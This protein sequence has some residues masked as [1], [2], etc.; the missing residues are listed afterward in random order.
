MQVVHTF[1]RIIR[2]WRVGPLLL[3]KNWPK[4]KQ[5][6]KRGRGCGKP[7]DVCVSEPRRRT[8]HVFYENKGKECNAVWMWRMC[9]C[10]SI[11]A[12]TADVR[13]RE[14]GAYERIY[15]GDFFCCVFLLLM[16][17]FFVLFPRGSNHRGLHDITSTS[18]P[19]PHR[20][21]IIFMFI[22]GVLYSLW[23]KKLFTPIF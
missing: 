7:H 3:R 22:F 10:L 8:R 15:L 11:L 14:F 9:C 20:N 2:E 5:G 13:K 18:P 23:L 19:S 1:K 16:L 6:M 4:K 17:L 12:A 21:M